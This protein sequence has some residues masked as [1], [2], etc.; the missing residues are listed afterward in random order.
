M[1]DCKNKGI[2][3]QIKSKCIF[4]NLMSDY[5]LEKVFNILQKKKPFEIIKYNNSTKHRLNLNIN[6][7]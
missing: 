5:F 4:N 3:N 1:E 7:Y 6:D 2:L